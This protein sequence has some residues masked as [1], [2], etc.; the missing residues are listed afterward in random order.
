MSRSDAWVQMLA[1]AT[2]TP[3]RV[4]SLETINGRAGAALVTGERPVL[5]GYGAAGADERTFI[6]AP[7]AE[8]GHA[9]GFATYRELYRAT[10]L[11]L[12]VA[13]A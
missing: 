5:P 3:A 13:G 9:T 11:E 7:A 1:D 2:G 10:Q 8:P 4:R 6:P 12:S